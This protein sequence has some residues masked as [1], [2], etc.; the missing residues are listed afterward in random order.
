MLPLKVSEEFFEMTSEEVNRIA[1]TSAKE[2]YPKVT[3]NIYFWAAM[4]SPYPTISEFVIKELIPFATTWLFEAGF[5][6]MSVLETKYRNRLD[7]EHD[8]RL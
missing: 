2:K 7:I 6:A 1:F 3:A 5:S 8:M 4:Y